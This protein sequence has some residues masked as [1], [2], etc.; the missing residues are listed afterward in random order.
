[1]IVIRNKKRRKTE[2]QKTTKIGLN[3]SKL[4]NIK[5]R[6]TITSTKNKK[7][8]NNLIIRNNVNDSKYFFSNKKKQKNSL[9]NPLKIKAST[10]KKNFSYNQNNKNIITYNNYSPQNHSF[11]LLKTS[12]KCFLKYNISKKITKKSSLNSQRHSFLQNLNIN[13]IENNIKSAINN[14]KIEIEKKEKEMKTY[15]TIFPKIKYNKLASSPNLILYSFKKKN[16]KTNKNLQTSFTEELRNS[17][18]NLSFQNKYLIKR[19]NSFD[20]NDLSK[21]KI[22]KK[23]KQKIFKPHSNDSLN[24]TNNEEDES[25]NKENIK[26][27]SF[28][29]NSNFIFIFD[30][31]LI[32]ATIFSFI[33]I[34]LSIAKNKDIREKEHFIKEIMNYL[35]DIIFLFDFIISFFRGYYNLEMIVVRNNKRIF[36]NYIKNYFIFDFIESIPIYTIYKNFTKLNNKNYAYNVNDI[37]SLLLFIKP[38]KILKIIRKKQ[39]KVLEDFYLYLS[40]N[41]Y[42]SKSIKFLIYFIIFSLF[43]H[44]LVCIHLY[45]SFLNY[46]NWIL[47][48]NLINCNFTKKYVTSLY[49]MITTLTTVGYGD[50]VCT[51]SIERIYHII[52][53][54]IGTLLYTFIVSK[55][56]N[57]LRE[58]SYEQIKLNKDLN[59]LENIRISYPSM[60]YKLYSKIKNHLQSVFAKKKK[61]GISLLINGVPEAIKSVLLL[62]IYS[63]V[64]NEFTIFKNVNNSNFILQ[65][66]TSFIPIVSK[67]EEIIILEKEIVQ[68]IIFVKDGRLS[69]EIAI[70]LNDPYNSIQKCIEVNFSG[71]SKQEEIK[72]NFNFLN[73]NSSSMNNYKKNY[74]DLKREIDNF[75]DNKKTSNIYSSQ[76]SNNRIS[77]DLGR[78][79]F[80][81]NQ[82]GDDNKDNFQIIKILDIRKNEYFGDIHLLTEKPSPFTIRT[83]SRIAELFLLRKRD[84]ISLSKNFS[85]I[86]KRIQSKSFHN[87]VSIKKLAFKTLKKYY[88]INIYN[89]N[90]KEANL[91][92]NL[93]VTK[94]SDI[95]F[96]DQSRHNISNNCVSKNL[97]RSIIQNNNKNK[98]FPL[99][100]SNYNNRVENTL[101]KS[102]FISE[103]NQKRKSIVESF[104]TELNLFSDS[105]KTNS[106]INN[107]NNSL[108]KFPKKNIK[109]KNEKFSLIKENEYST[110]NSFDNKNLQNISNNFT[111]QNGKYE[112]YTLISPKKQ[113]KNSQLMMNHSKFKNFLE[114]NQSQ[115]KVHSFISTNSYNEKNNQTK[116]ENIDAKINILT[117][118]ELN[119]NF[120]KKIKKILIKRKKFRK[121]KGLL[122]SRKLKLNKNIFELYSQENNKM[123]NKCLIE[124]ANNIN[125]SFTSSEKKE[126][127]EIID[128]T[129]TSFCNNNFELEKLKN[130]SIQSFEIKA[131]Y[132]NLNSLSNGEI[133]KNKNYKNF[134]EKIIKKKI[135]KII[136]KNI[137]E[138][139]LSFISRLITRE[140]NKKNSFHS[141]KEIKKEKINEKENFSE[142]EITSAMIN[143]KFKRSGIDE[144]KNISNRKLYY[145]KKSAKMNKS[146][147]EKLLND[148]NSTAVFGVGLERTNVFKCDNN[149]F[150]RIDKSKIIENEILKSKT[151]KKNNELGNQ[152]YNLKESN[153]NSKFAQTEKNSIIF[154][155]NKSYENMKN[156][157]YLNEF[158]NSY[159]DMIQI[160]NTNKENSKKCLIF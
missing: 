136:S 94:N 62:K 17:D 53:L 58:Q 151:L 29:P 103:N 38:F 155:T 9:D 14:M 128:S 131:S 95:S 57:Y 117:L 27:F 68:N 44:L 22:L 48:S 157:Q 99:Q 158:N 140:K 89:K 120:S 35:I 160:Y 39:N 106:N 66:L 64:I 11:E 3:I 114:I 147:K 154:P 159:E 143:N 110:L 130:I 152:I 36:Y 49:F 74:N 69:M 149:K 81:R 87:L 78:L 40:E 127:C 18:L 56:G 118:D 98:N 82:I 111:F 2:D 43:I 121:L 67:K 104:D 25:D 137:Y 15:N 47:H 134:I 97:D 145:H 119:R 72:H 132:K 4:N 37:H 1:M 24:T 76:L 88:N 105:E 33:F 70:D 80:S 142:R 126:I 112:E 125:C 93:D 21:K 20:Y 54:A 150:S 61:T 23:I 41:Y 146:N 65:V 16:K 116:T 107:N 31:I 55:F 135:N 71:I 46:P 45:I 13:L 85:N 108:F 52:L 28:N 26:G 5:L 32:F 77:V 102:K 8:D 86:C 12:T 60:S 51:S 6:Y 113:N 148:N 75:I 123:E 84:A 10:L 133:I 7:K 92:F 101:N 141:N 19:N 144:S 50:I 124:K 73:R 122:E 91:P 115:D 30:L 100:K 153:I 83:K 34:P 42:L 79:D 59:I 139:I 129:N 96:L 156:S 90:N 63:N 109:D 138:K